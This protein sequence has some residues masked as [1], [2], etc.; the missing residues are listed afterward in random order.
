MTSKKNA[1][2]RKMILDFDYL[3][4]PIAPPPKG[5]GQGKGAAKAKADPKRAEMFLN[6]DTDKD[7]KLSK[8]EFSA[9]RNPADAAKWF[10]ARDQNKDGFVD[11]PEYITSTV[12]NP[13][14]P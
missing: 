9:K 8:V 12:P 6:L 11:E 4:L 3:P 14:K 5:K 7:G 1:L 10:E 13:P 2:Q